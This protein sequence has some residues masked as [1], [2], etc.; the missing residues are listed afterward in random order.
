MATNDAATQ[1]RTD[2]PRTLPGVFGIDQAGYRHRLDRCAATI[3]VTRGGEVDRVEQLGAEDLDRALDAWVQFV[4][5][6]RGWIDEWLDA[7]DVLEATRRHEAA[8][9]AAAQLGEH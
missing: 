5:E 9:D 1:E 6:G 3:Y 4:D 2:R 7:D 8:L